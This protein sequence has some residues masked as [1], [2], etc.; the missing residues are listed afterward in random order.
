[1]RAKSLFIFLTL[2]LSITAHSKVVEKVLAVVEGQ[3]ILKSELNS[4][5]ARLKKQ[6]LVN[7]NLLKFLKVTKATKSQKEILDYLV[8]K[9]IITS[10]AKKDLNITSLDE[11]TNKELSGLAQQ[12]KIS[13]QQLKKEIT[14][15]GINFQDYKDFIGE[16]S[17]IRS[18]LEKNVISQVRPTE[19]DFVGYLK[20]NGVTGIKP[21][22]TFNL[23]QIFIPNKNIKSSTLA[24]SITSD[25]FKEYFLNP[26]KLKIESL[27]LGELKS[28]DLSKS[29]AAAVVAASQGAVSKILEEKNGYRIFFINSKKGN[30]NIPNTAKVRKLQQTY[31]DSKI[32]NQF[33]TWFEEL[34][35]KFFVRING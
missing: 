13:V 1:M 15:R 22:Y 8:A 17:L 21:S 35:P 23:D 19:E 9:K 11:I 14:S 24:K 31:Y 2:F 25:N 34:K 20:R 7:E 10:F 29:H 4:F 26:K 12:N 18:A 6:S 30:F 32:Q 16:S 27:K 33:K 5:Q 28:V 3:M